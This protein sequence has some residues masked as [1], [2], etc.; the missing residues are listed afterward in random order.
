MSEAQSS[1]PPLPWLPCF[2]NQPSA[3]G[4]SPANF[5]TMKNTNTTQITEADVIAF[6]SAKLAELRNATKIN[7]AHI[8]LNVGTDGIEWTTYVDSGKHCEAL[9]IDDAIAAQVECLTD[10]GR[11]ARAKEARDHA[12]RLIAEAD[13]LEAAK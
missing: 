13:R 5:P 6:V 4:R 3:A 10:N 12:A 2:F 1:S 9:T 11:T 7:Y 8:R